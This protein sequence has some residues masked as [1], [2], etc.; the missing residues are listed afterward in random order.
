MKK[1]EAHL[2]KEELASV[3]VIGSHYYCH[4]QNIFKTI[5]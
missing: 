2:T 4:E 1:Q 3:R 5:I